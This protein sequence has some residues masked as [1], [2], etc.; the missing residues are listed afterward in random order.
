MRRHSLLFLLIGLTSVGLAID[1]PPGLS[2]AGIPLLEDFTPT[3][4]AGVSQSWS[5]AQDSDGLI[6]V[7][8][9]VGILQFDG[10]RWRK[11]SLPGDSAFAVAADATGRIYAGGEGTF[12]YLEPDSV[13]CLAY[14]PLETVLPDSLRKFGSVT[15][16]FPRRDELLVLSD[17]ALYRLRNDTFESY[18]P[19]A[20]VQ[21]FAFDVRDSIYVWDFEVG[22]R[23]LDRE[24]GLSPLPGLADTDE[25]PQT[26]WLPLPDGRFLASHFDS[27]RLQAWDGEQLEDFPNEAADYLA[28][29][30]IYCGVTLPDDRLALGTL[31]GGLV[32][33][34][35]DGRLAMTLTKR[36]GLPDERILGMT[37]DREGGLWLAMSQGIARVEVSGE[38]TVF[39]E[40][41]GISGGLDQIL[42]HDGRLY[43]ATNFGVYRLEDTAGPPAVMAPVQGLPPQIFSLC[44]TGDQ[45]LCGTVEGVSL[46]D[47]LK[48]RALIEY[49]A[50]Y[51]L[52]LHPDEDNLVI[53]GLSAGL[54]RLQKIDNK[55]RT[56]G[57]VPD[58]DGDVRELAID[59][60][61]SLW[62]GTGFAGVHRFQFADGWAA[63]PTL[64]ESFGPEDGLGD[65]ECEVF[66]LGDHVVLLTDDN[67]MLQPQ[68]A[69]QVPRFTLDPTLGLDLDGFDSDRYGVR[70]SI[71]GD[72]WICGG[73][74]PRIGL[75]EASGDYTWK[76][77]HLDR[78]RPLRTPAIHRDP[79][80]VIWT[81][82]VHGLIRWNPHVEAPRASSFPCVVRAVRTVGTDSLLYGGLIDAPRLT[83]H[84]TAVRFEFASPRFDSPA[85][86]R[87][88]TRLNGLGNEWSS[89]SDETHRDFTNLDGGDYCFEVQ[90]R[91]AHGQ[92]SR[93]GTFA[94]RVPT[95]WHQTV[96]ARVI[97]VS[98]VLAL[99]FWLASLLNRIRM[100]QLEEVVRKRTAE[101]EV[102][103]DEAERANLAK[104]DF[105][106]NVSHE[107]R[108]PMNG[109]LGMATLL[110]DTDLETE[111]R[112]H[113]ETI[114]S[115]GN[116]LLSLINDILDL[117]K[118]E[119][120][121][122]EVIRESFDLYACLRATV[123]V[124]APTAE[125]K[126]LALVLALHP[127]LPQLVKGDQ[128]RLRQVVIN[129]L[130]NAVKFTA[131]GEVRLSVEADALDDGERT[132]HVRVSDT[133]I[134]IPADV[135]PSL[136][137]PFTQADRTIS[138]RFGGTGL[139][140][141]I[142]RQLVELMNGTIDVESVPGRGSVFRFTIRVGATAKRESVRAIRESS[143]EPPPIDTL[144][145]LRILVVDDNRVNLRVA[146][147]MLKSLGQTTDLAADGEEAVA[148]VH[149][150]NYD[151]VLM[152]RKMP[153][154]DGLGAT[155]RIR[156]EVPVALQPRIVAMTA[157][158]TAEDRQLCLDSGMDD[159]I[160]KP[161]HRQALAEVL[162]RVA[163]QIPVR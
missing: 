77:V 80:G 3:D 155:K 69:D 63:D 87:Y 76:P 1:E 115:C 133:G 127:D 130:S 119:A 129:L 12:G 72:T 27:G 38:L 61:G 154:L 50:G 36:E 34:E 74:T 85:H 135:L 17:R 49:D 110:L 10:V 97:A 137:Q 43:V 32:V 150:G 71:D 116:N 146:Q 28:E 89:W 131:S 107:I 81:G 153:G 125:A 47:G 24:N 40:R 26:I 152:D 136:F 23:V 141:A 109:V 64:H 103:R 121:Q 140:L 111:Q 118:I 93:V 18:V 37:V 84:I 117:S 113:A 2:H 54:L 67:R 21:Q 44:S 45:L 120:G 128:L 102:A 53:V 60:D 4:V 51:S 31:S 94:F 134:G 42:R 112:Q 96:A 33:L 82:E 100:H 90:S 106:A 156:K 157:S 35:P 25:D 145:A 9:M 104:S 13:G 86:Q 122:L 124:V 149:D 142:S 14:T 56:L 48:S 159:F 39:D 22:L 132:L 6:Y 123:D 68:P 73:E 83:E 29:H 15:R 139:G 108:T 16:I 161:V 19:A 95:P 75:R 147:G 11:I 57:L 70:C 58:F 7:A 5:V 101:L 148:R 143:A 52:L 163:E 79:D 144:P 8:N 46:I 65:G 105:L 151:L 99:V 55:W 138:H 88:R 78:A 59:T 114:F 66:S 92:L 158:V 41:R 30:S 162:A 160:S 126:G 62:V 91:D 98:I 20:H